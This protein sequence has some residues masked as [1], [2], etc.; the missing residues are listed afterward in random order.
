[1]AELDFRKIRVGVV[2]AL[3]SDSDLL[4]ELVLK[5]GN[6]LALVHG[7]GSRTS[8]DLDFSMQG[9][10]GDLGVA[11]DKLK[12]ALDRHFN[13]DGYVVFDFKFE[14]KPPELRAEDWLGYRLE[15]KLL[16]K[17]KYETLSEIRRS[18]QA[19]VIGP[20]QKRVF[21]IDFSCHEYTQ[22]KVEYE[23]NDYPV[24][25]YSPAMI[26]IEKLRALCQQM[27]EYGKRRRKKPRPR[28]LYDI[29]AIQDSVEFVTVENR[30][31][32]IRIF[33][34]KDVPF[35]LLEKLPRYRDFHFQQW[36]AVEASAGPG[37]ENY[38]FY[39]DKVVDL[40]IKAKALWDI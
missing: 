25:A 3:C 5:G 19:A 30:E 6:A 40:A 7:I 26:G 17:E 20:G 22:P 32:A 33:Q 27:E 36:T 4:E 11:E 2:N 15:F 13:L 34:S 29:V 10:F 39:F 8:L 1:M 37:L 28:D 9:S 35:E 23:L 16:R 31:L 14:Q 38:D 12:R 21:S 18:V 24:F